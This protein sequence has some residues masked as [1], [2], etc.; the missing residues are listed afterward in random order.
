MP[1]KK[2]TDLVPDE[3]DL[4]EDTISNA[5]LEVGATLEDE[6]IQKAESATLDEYE[7]MDD[8]EAAGLDE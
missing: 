8:D 1:R 6:M 4:Q 5:D 7:V 2:K 3:T